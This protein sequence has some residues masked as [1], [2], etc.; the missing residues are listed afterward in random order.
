MT[1]AYF[2]YHCNKVDKTYL[3]ILEY[4]TPQLQVFQ[5]SDI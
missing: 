5:L 4:S 1:G 2:D 3:L